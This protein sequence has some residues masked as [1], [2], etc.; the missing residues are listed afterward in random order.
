MTGF[1]FRGYPVFCH[2]VRQ[3]VIP[4]R[5]RV[6]ARPTGALGRPEA[7]SGG[8]LTGYLPRG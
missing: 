6:L 7:R 5:L 4:S 1:S 8:A 3:V 2:I